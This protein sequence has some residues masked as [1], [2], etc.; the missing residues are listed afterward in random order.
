MAKNVQLLGL[1]RISP[2]GI[3]TIAM[4]VYCL[5]KNQMDSVISGTIGS[6]QILSHEISINIEP[7]QYSLAQF[8]VDNFPTVRSIM[9]PPMSKMLLVVYM[10]LLAI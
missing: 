1:C 7:S 3:P 8:W 5:N 6:T 2:P 4:Y 9:K 10:R